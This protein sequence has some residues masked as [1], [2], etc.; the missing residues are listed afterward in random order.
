MRIPHVVYRSSYT[1]QALGFHYRQSILQCELAGIAIRSGLLC[2]RYRVWHQPHP[3]RIFPLGFIQPHHIQQ[4]QSIPGPIATLRY[5]PS[6]GHRLHNQCIIR[7]KYELQSTGHSHLK[8]DLVISILASMQIFHSMELSP[9]W[10]ATRPSATQ[11][12]PNILWNPNVQEYHHMNPYYQLCRE[13]VNCAAKPP[14]LF[15]YD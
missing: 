8:C 12:F 14:K 3:V 7:S 15:T 4:T 11:E 2:A 5:M 6:S 10:E 13:W 9:S 1:S